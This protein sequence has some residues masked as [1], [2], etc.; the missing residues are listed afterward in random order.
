M[1]ISCLD[2]FFFVQVCDSLVPTSIPNLGR[3]LLLHR[4]FFSL[5]FSFESRMPLTIS[6]GYLLAPSF[7]S[8][9]MR[10]LD[11]KE[12]KIIHII[13]S[14]AFFGLPGSPLTSKTPPSFFPPVLLYR[15]FS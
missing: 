3:L 1:K 12:G 6:C 10:I 7:K 13:H 15:I 9:S 11:I 8:T 5:G 14:I 2:Y 4:V